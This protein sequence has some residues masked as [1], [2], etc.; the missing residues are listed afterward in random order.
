MISSSPCTTRSGLRGS[1]RHAASRLATSRR[2]ST[3]RSTSRPPSDDMW[4]PSK[5]AIT[6]LPPMGDRP[7]RAG[8]G[9]T[10]AGIRLQIGR[11][12]VSNHILPWIKGLYYARQPS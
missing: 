11:M 4:L 12:G 5:R 6:G 8:V 1:V 9:S 10:L 7:G 3:L 2:R